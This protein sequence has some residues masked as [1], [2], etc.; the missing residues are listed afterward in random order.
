[1]F[2]LRIIG[3]IILLG[4]VSVELHSQN[5]IALET[6]WNDSFKEW[7][8]YTEDENT[9]GSLEML[10]KMEG[11]LTEWTFEIDELTGRIK[12]RTQNPGFWEFRSG[13]EIITAQTV[14]PGDSSEWRFTDGKHVIILKSK[15][16]EIPTVW[17]TRG[18]E[19]GYMDIFREYEEDP[20]IWLVE[21]FLN[22]EISPL[23][24]LGLVFV[25]VFHSTPKL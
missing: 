3:F 17:F 20:T 23:Y 16:Y 14:W 24:R 11:D 10:W 18:E 25:A 15:Y 13:N 5:I 12:L 22:D 1:M 6:K 9:E 7:T 4:S 21:D 2:L 19:F 8:I